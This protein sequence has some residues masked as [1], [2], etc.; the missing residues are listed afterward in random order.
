MHNFGIVI[1]IS[2]L[3]FIMNICQAAWSQN[4]VQPCFMENIY[5]PLPSWETDTQIVQIRTRSS[6]FV[7]Y[8]MAVYPYSPQTVWYSGTYP[9][10]Y[11]PIL[12]PRLD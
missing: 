10:S 9:I 1:R 5:S 7:N 3:F 11:P 2:L 4:V 12:F 8:P 6:S